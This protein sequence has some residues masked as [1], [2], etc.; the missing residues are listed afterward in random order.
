MILVPAMAKDR[1]A[2]RIVDC[3]PSSVTVVIPA[4]N[5]EQSIAWVLERLP[6]VVGEVIPVDGPWTDRTIEI[7]RAIRPDLKVVLE[8]APGKGAA[9]RAGFAAAT[10]DFIVRLNADG[11]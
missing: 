1:P 3:P 9:L 2:D 4:L 8:Q 6:D 5:E 10:G 7:S 11:A